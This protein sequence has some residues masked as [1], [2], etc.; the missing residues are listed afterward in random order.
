MGYAGNYKA[1]IIKEQ[2][3]MKKSGLSEPKLLR[4]INPGDKNTYKSEVNSVI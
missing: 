4:L 1:E 2:G 3:R